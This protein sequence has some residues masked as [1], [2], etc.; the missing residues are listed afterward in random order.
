VF[1]QPFGKLGISV[2]TISLGT[3]EIGM[4]YGFYYP[5]EKAVPEK[6]ESVRLLL[7]AFES[8][9]NLLDTSPSYG[10]SEE[11]VG[12]ALK[13]W[14]EEVYVATKIPVGIGT[15]ELCRSIESSL[16]SLK[17]E[18]IDLVQIHN[19]EGKDL[20]CGPYW[21]T[22]LALRKKGYVRWIGA[23]VYG[24]ENAEAALRHP[25]I[26]VL[27]VACNLLDQGMIERI[28]P[29]A[30]EKGVGILIRSALLKGVLSDRRSFLP[31]AL[32]LLK[33]AAERAGRWAQKYEM[34]LPIA[35]IRFC[36][37][38]ARNGSVLLGVRNA[39]ELETAL[40]AASFPIDPQALAE[41]VSLHLNEKV[42][43]PRTWDRLSGNPPLP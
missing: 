29:A 20:V 25:Q 13:E 16:R 42:T 36:M 26:A 17:R 1:Y 27:Q 5:G 39:E 35:A 34:D 37:A 10:G 14:R 22:L 7:Q 43:D 12:Q 41:A 40:T 6:A 15:E 24:L 11:I 28:L 33:E 21:E 32:T 38:Q 30:A 3:V 9:V 2:S 31:A 8:G 23:S 4:P 18:P 19:A